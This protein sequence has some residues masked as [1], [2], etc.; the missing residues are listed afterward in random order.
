[1]SGAERHCVSWCGGGRRGGEGRGQRFGNGTERCCVCCPALL[2]TLLLLLLLL[3]LPRLLR[4]VRPL[5]CTLAARLHALAMVCA[6]HN[7]DPLIAMAQLGHCA[8][9]PRVSLASGLGAICPLLY[10]RLPRVM[11]QPSSMSPS[12]SH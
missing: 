4:S 10:A 8:D 5:R 12:C 9:S 1:M 3:L 2:S 6:S 11:W 7:E